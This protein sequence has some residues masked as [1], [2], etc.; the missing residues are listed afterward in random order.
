MNETVLSD[1]IVVGFINYGESDRIVKL[2]SKERGLISAIAK[3]IRSH[4]HKWLGLLEVGNTLEVT[5][6][7]P[8]NDLWLLTGI[9]EIGSTSIIRKDL[10]KL[11]TMQY[12]CEVTGVVSITDD[13]N[14]KLYGLLEHT[15]GLLKQMPTPGSAVLNGFAIKALAISGHPPQLQTC[16]LC[17]QPIQ[18]GVDRYFHSALGSMIHQGCLEAPQH[19]PIHTPH[20]FQTPKQWAIDVQALLKQPMLSYWESNIS[21]VKINKRSATWL[22]TEMIEHTV[23]RGVRS[24]SV[25]QTLYP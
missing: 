20:L 7:P 25:L 14:P 4:K 19:Q 23:E 11:S 21:T 8:K 13:P 24:R 10:L 1:C 15:L 17:N 2:F 5:L 12:C 6:I 22:L 9:Q 16:T 3:R 18:T